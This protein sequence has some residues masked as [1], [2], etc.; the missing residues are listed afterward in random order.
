M[1]LDTESAFLGRLRS[2]QRLEMTLVAHTVC[3][4]VDRPDKNYT[5]GQDTNLRLPRSPQWLSR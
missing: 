1:I 2:A 4:K 5:Q 3:K